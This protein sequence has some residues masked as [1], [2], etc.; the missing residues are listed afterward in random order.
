MSIAHTL[1][2]KSGSESTAT[3]TVVSADGAPAEGPK[4]LIPY[5]FG[6]HNIYYL[7]T[8][9]EV[10]N[11]LQ[12]IEGGVVGFD[13]EYDKRK[14]TDEEELISR[15]MTETSG[16]KKWGILAWQVIQ[17][18]TYK[19][20]K[21]PVAWD[22]IALCVIQLARGPDVWVMNVR[23][24]RAYPREL[25]HVLT[26]PDIVK[27]SVGVTNDFIHLWNDFRS[28]MKNVVDVGCM[29]RLLLAHKHCTTL[30]ANMSLQ[31]SAEEIL[32]YAVDKEE[33]ESDW[34]GQLSRKQKIFDQKKK[35]KK[36]AAIDA[37]VSLKLYENLHPALNEHKTQLGVSIPE[38]WY[39]INS[40]YGE[41]TRKYPTIW[42]EV[43]PWLV[44]DC[45]WFANGRFQ[46]Y[47]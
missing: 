26:S 42:N 12:H 36:N 16:Q 7:T 17:Q 31:S 40:R 28:D 43:M 29:A 19:E 2:V 15:V 41:P 13:T 47:T 18:E 8:E 46:G 45:Y 6:Q 30:Y 38:N 33:R 5:P 1:L 10:N 27:A 14:P 39:S 34:T 32:C 9:D 21:F 4:N 11:A 37:A 25:E 23:S 22:N 44:K 3:N 24:M 20:T 35:K